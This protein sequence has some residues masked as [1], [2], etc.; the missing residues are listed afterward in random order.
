[1]SPLDVFRCP[2][3]GINL[4]EASAGTGKTWNICGL[5]LRLLLERALPVQHILVVTFTNAATAELRDRIRT[6]IAE[7]LA[8]LRGPQV[9][10]GADPFI[11]GLLQALRDDPALD[12]DTLRQRLD[13]AL[14]TFDEAAIFTI[15]GFCQRALADTP[16]TAQMPL[17]LE[18]VADDSDLLHQVAADLWRREVAAPG[19][20]PLLAA[21]LARGKDTPDTWAAL[22]K[23][24]LAKPLSAVLWPDGLDT[25]A[26]PATLAAPLQ[27]AHDAARQLWQAGRAAT[28]QALMDGLPRLSANTYKPEAVLAAAEGWDQVLAGADAAAAL[29]LTPKGLDLLGRDRIEARTKKG[30]VPPAHAFFGAAQALLDA[31]A[32]AA[33]AVA[34]QRLAL[35]RRVLEQGAQAV[36]DHKREQRVIAFDDMLYNLHERLAGPHGPALADS[37]RARFP[38]ALIDEFQDTDP[39][40]FAIFQRLYADG[41]RPLFFV[42]DPKQAIYSFRNA[43]LHTYLHARAQAT[44][45]YTLGDNQRSSAALI[46]ALNAFFGRNPRAFLLNDLEYRPVGVGAKPRT[47]FEDRSQPARAPL[48]CWSLPP[49]AEGQPLA[50]SQALG[51]T[52]HACAAEVSRLLR[53]ARAGE[54][55]LGARP[56]AAGDIAVL[57]RSHSQGARMRLALAALNIGSVELSQA[58]V[59]Q[60]PD[61]EAMEW[62]LAAILEPTRERRLRAA[63]ATEWMGLDAGEIDAVS[64]DE[65]RLLALVQRFAQYRHVWLDRGV[66]VMLRHWMQGEA[67]AERLLARSDGERR[68]TNLLHLAELLHAAAEQHSAPAALLQWL[69][70]QRQAGQADEAAQLRLESD[71]NLV[72][73]VT[74]HKSKGLEYP[75]VFCPFLWD[76]RAMPEPGGDAVEYHDADGRP[77][78]DFRLH[79]KAALAEIKAQRKRDAAA[80]FLRL[81]YVALTRAVH[82]CYLVTGAYAVRNSCTEANR[83]LLNW[84]AAGAGL[85]PEAWGTHKNPAEWVTAEWASLAAECTPDIVHEPLPTEPGL[86][87]PPAETAAD[88]LV[89]LPPPAVLPQAWWIGSYSSLASGARHEAAAID[90]DLRAQPADLP[91]PAPRGRLAED[92]ILRFPRGPA[93]GDAL[94]AVF[95]QVRFD[96]ATQWPEGIRR[97]LA[98]HPQPL[99]TAHL[100]GEQPP[101]E[102]MLLR[103]L[104]DVLNT[105]LPTGDAQAGPVRLSSLMPRQQLVELEF[106]LPSRGLTA[107]DLTEALRDLGYPTPSLVFGGL[108]GYLRGFIDLV[109][110]HG[111]RYYLLDWKSNH[112]GD[113][114]E[115]YGREALADAM[116]GH[117]YHL[118]YLLYAVALQ[119]HLQRRLPDYRHE[120]HF[121]GVFYLFVRGVRPGWQQPDGLPAGVYFHRPAEATLQRLSALLGETEA[122]A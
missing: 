37:L 92:D 79:D 43:D 58:S 47:R 15:H 72:Q 121:G 116:A 62:L 111:G 19:L 83:S 97:A 78:L 13:S 80:E 76:G 20:P 10:E 27:A 84:L 48:H 110:E 11:T 38:A 61:A 41:L 85:D 9:A 106:T 24:R 102:P 98:L 77:V 2:L 86:P 103:M 56:L 23:R 70:R 95:E 109:F 29:A 6:R 65:S 69:Q 99:S 36:R 104:D 122:A 52:A 105:P 115:H 30:L 53:A 31:R 75:V 28:V 8:W 22:L 40:Q 90:H 113:A 107:G 33:Q 57:V 119:R 74:V 91:V 71:R 108:E 44:A 14:Q 35:L 49:D 12:D 114:A 73:I 81:V 94:H 87:V 89:A 4:I 25:A 93:A 26:D 18:L 5:Y 64:A 112:L 63:L 120:R 50:K 88:A 67:V 21:E 42:G 55:T 82:R 117:G 101:L 68:L 66:G 59:F 17:S 7:V 118:Q 3:G 16:F 46:G 51:R 45:E 1:M 32:A 96:D 60:G 54:L 100:T 34:L 39:L